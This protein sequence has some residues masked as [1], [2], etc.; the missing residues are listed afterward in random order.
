[1]NKIKTG[2]W[3]ACCRLVNN[4]DNTFSL[5]TALVKRQNEN[6]VLALSKEVVDP[7]DGYDGEYIAAAFRKSLLNISDY[8]VI[9]LDR[10]FEYEEQRA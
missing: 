8:P 1:M 2:V 7:T 10:M 3:P 6:V 4:Q 5:R 9:P